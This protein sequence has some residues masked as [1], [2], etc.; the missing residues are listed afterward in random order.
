MKIT[1]S[2]T[3]IIIGSALAIGCRPG[4]T[5]NNTKQRDAV[6]LSAALKLGS[7][8]L[9]KIV[10]VGESEAGQDYAARLYAAAKRIETEHALAG[11]DMELVLQ[12]DAWRKA[13]SDCRVGSYDLAAVHFGGGTM[14]G[15]D[16]M[17]DCV[18]LETFLAGLAKRLPL[19][20]GNGS[21]RAAKQID[22]TIAFIE[23]FKQANRQDMGTEGGFA[24]KMERITGYWM[25]LKCLL[26]DIPEGEADKIAA[27]AVESLD[28]M[29]DFP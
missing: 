12:L 24:E 18:P 14:H 22:D 26:R 10:D 13:L 19:A 9:T 1:V 6:T 29:K 23:N 28:C 27:F 21:A 25:H 11:H 20:H 17:R 7:D 3:A 2:L 5:E 4:D 15:H 8:R 16:A